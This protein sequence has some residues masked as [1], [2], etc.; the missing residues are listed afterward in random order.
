MQFPSQEHVRSSLIV[1]V[2]KA[3][4]VY[5]SPVLLEADQSFLQEPFFMNPLKLPHSTPI[6]EGSTHLIPP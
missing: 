5:F 1:R 3:E 6:T 4:S 2:I